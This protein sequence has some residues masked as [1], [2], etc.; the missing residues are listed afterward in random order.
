ME[1]DDVRAARRKIRVVAAAMGGSIFVYAGVAFALSRMGARPTMVLD[2]ASLKLAFTGFLIVSVILFI[3]SIALRRVLTG[4][5]GA[6]SSDPARRLF[7]ATIIACA[8]AEGA[9]ILGLI[10]FLLGGAFRDALLFFAIGFIGVV[11]AFPTRWALEPSG[12]LDAPAD[13][14]M[15]R[16]DEKGEPVP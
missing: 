3:L 10:Y 12:G 1:N 7:R 2:D 13:A 15:N 9:G 16:D 8:L 6:S 5:R 14:E 4:A 11:Y